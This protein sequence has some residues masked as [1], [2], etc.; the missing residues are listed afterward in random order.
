MENTHG[1]ERKK[2]SHFQKRKKICTLL[3]GKNTHGFR[4]KY[5]RFLSVKNTHGFQRKKNARYKLEKY[6]R[7]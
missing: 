4:K 5:A 7:F 3:S 2:Y 1:S 6:A